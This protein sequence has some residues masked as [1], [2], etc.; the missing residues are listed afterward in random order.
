[1][2]LKGTQ[3]YMG[4]KLRVWIL[5][6]YCG[7]LIFLF[8]NSYFQHSGIMWYGLLAHYFGTIVHELLLFLFHVQV[9]LLC[10]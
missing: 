1:M 3:E 10:T 5:L 8:F 7:P 2:S 4:L 6:Q 9:I